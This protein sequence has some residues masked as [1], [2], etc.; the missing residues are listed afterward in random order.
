MTVS[1]AMMLV[2]GRISVVVKDDGGEE[3]CEL[4]V[5]VGDVDTN[6]RTDDGCGVLDG[7][8]DGVCVR[9]RR[10]FMRATASCISGSF[11]DALI[12]ALIV[13]NQSKSVSLLSGQA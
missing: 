11:V 7:K 8:S 1:V 2:L 6:E 5:C 9:P 10:M 12:V 13:Q 4:L 3:K